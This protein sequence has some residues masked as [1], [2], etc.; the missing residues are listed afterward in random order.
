MKYEDIAC[1]QY[2]R[3]NNQNMIVSLSQ[4]SYTYRIKIKELVLFLE[5]RSG[6]KHYFQFY[7][8]NKK[9]ID[10]YSWD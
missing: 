8:I 1:V 4:M 5:V 10:N 2:V 7:K 6:N 9:L 3:S